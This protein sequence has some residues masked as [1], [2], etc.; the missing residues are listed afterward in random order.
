MTQR[1]AVAFIR[2]HGIVLEAARGPV[3]SLAAAVARGPIRGSWWAHPKGR[4][5]FA[6]TRAMRSCKDVLVCRLVE[7]KITFVHRRLWAA[8]VRA[9]GRIAHERLAQVFEVHS[10]SGSHVTRQ[11]PFPKWVPADVRH[12]A[13]ALSEERAMSQ[14]AAVI[15]IDDRPAVRPT[16][17]RGRRSI[18]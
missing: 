9:S 4:E 18:G 7:G 11:I 14:F 17:R 6:V 1:Q 16:R 8:L 12:R 10:A 3:P 2:K 13:R 15:D 5:I